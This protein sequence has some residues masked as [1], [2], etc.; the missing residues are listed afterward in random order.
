MSAWTLSI[1]WLRFT[2]PQAIVDEIIR[3]IGVD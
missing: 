1:S 2:V 3:L